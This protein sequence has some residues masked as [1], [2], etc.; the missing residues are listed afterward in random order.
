MT[1]CLYHLQI[2]VMCLFYFYFFNLFLYRW[3][4]WV[5]IR[6]ICVSD[7]L[8]VQSWPPACGDSAERKAADARTKKRSLDLFASLSNCIQYAAVI[9]FLRRHWNKPTLEIILIAIINLFDVQYFGGLHTT[10]LLLNVGQFAP[11]SDE[12]VNRDT[13]KSLNQM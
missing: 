10:L 4:K 6:C 5:N 3:P 8:L 2:P 7:S 13:W 1:R 11:W 9:C 12:V